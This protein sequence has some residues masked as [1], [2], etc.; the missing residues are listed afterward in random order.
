LKAYGKGIVWV[1][2]KGFGPI[3]NP[4]SKKPRDMGPISLKYAGE[5]TDLYRL[6]LAPYLPV[7]FLSPEE[8]W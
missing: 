6:V 8:G 5:N 1:H 3:P 2:I 4:T 7:Y